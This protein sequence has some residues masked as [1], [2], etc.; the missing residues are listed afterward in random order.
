M[1]RVVVCLLLLRG[2]SCKPKVPVKVAAPPP[3]HAGPPEYQVA[4]MEAMKAFRLGTSESYK[5]AT[6]SFRRAAELE[7][8]SCE[9]ALHLAESLYLWPSNRS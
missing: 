3:Q 8:T 1:K 7:R 4:Y 6:V 5:Q 9:Y 2:T